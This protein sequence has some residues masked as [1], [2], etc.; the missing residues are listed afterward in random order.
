M[1]DS[2]AP[3]ARALAASIIGIDAIPV[4]VEARIT[5][6]APGLRLIGLP[7]HD[8]APTDVRAR[9]LAAITASTVDWPQR[10]I[11]VRLLPTALPKPGT[12]LDL[13]IATAML[14]ANG[15]VPVKA[16]ARTLFI[17]EL[18]PDGTIR[19]VPG[20]VPAARCADAIGADAIVVPPANAAEARLVGG[21]TVLTAGSLRE[22]V[23]LLRGDQ[24]GNGPDAPPIP[25]GAP[26]P[27]DPEALAQRSTADPT[28]R[29]IPDTSVLALAAS[30]AGGHHLLV[31]GT[32]G[33]ATQILADTL[34][35][36]LPPLDVDAELEVAAIHSVAGL[37]DTG[38]PPSPKPP[39]AHLS[40]RE[41]LADLQGGR[42]APHAL[43][44]PGAAALAHLGV[45]RVDDL[46]RMHTTVLNAIADTLHHKRPQTSVIEQS[47]YRYPADFLLAA[48]VTHHPIPEHGTE[49]GPGRD[50]A[51]LS[52]FRHHLLHHIP[53]RLDLQPDSPS[54]HSTSAGPASNTDGSWTASLAAAAERVR[55]A[56]DRARKRLDGTG[57]SLNAQLQPRHLLTDFPPAIDAIA[58]LED[59]RTGRHIS[60]I[61][62]I[63]VAKLAWT[64]ADLDHAPR[65]DLDHVV[66]AMRYRYPPSL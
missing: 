34:A 2:A 47:G 18:D 64:L 19:A 10:H 44:Q 35:D 32:P 21:V 41:D 42:A 39:V 15:T 33:S 52:P 27:A 22:L 30:A 11:T 62:M 7:D 13:P 61:G 4:R 46:T 6:G 26:P 17:G 37:L 40:P 63:D 23:T 43:Y 28:A 65:P 57:V 56:R 29:D 20:V 45:L 49:H 31:R 5:P 50:G 59:A 48:T 3:L 12:G 38:R 1:V 55:E 54:G 58:Y 36:L 53:L 14:A 66:Q 8:T 9:V 51:G 16:C 60:F 25:P 24:P